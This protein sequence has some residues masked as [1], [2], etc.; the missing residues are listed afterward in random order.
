MI[1][2]LFGTSLF[3]LIYIFSRYSTGELP[4]GEDCVFRRPPVVII[5]VVNCL[6]HTILH[7]TPHHPHTTPNTTPTLH[8]RDGG[9]G[10]VGW[11][12]GTVG[13]WDSGTVGQWDSG[14]RLG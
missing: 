7:T 11:D 6:G 13:Q 9:G 4:E 12:S 1:A 10:G 14:V 3:L 5:Y 8:Q 2:H